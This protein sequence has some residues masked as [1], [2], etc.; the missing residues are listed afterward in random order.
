M[1]AEKTIALGIFKAQVALAPVTSF[2]NEVSDELH[3]LTSARQLQLAKEL[4]IPQAEINR[5]IQYDTMSDLIKSWRR[6]HRNVKAASQPYEF[7][8]L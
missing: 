8:E 6:I 5:A 7:K 1:K 3:A 2:I 4:G